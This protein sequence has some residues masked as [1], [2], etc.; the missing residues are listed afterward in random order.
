[1]APSPRTLVNKRPPATSLGTAIAWIVTL[2]LIVGMLGNFGLFVISLSVHFGAWF[3]D[4]AS[5]SLRPVAMVAGVGVALVV[6][7]GSLIAGAA[8]LG[9]GSGLAADR[10]RKRT[11]ILSDDIS[12]MSQRKGAKT[13]RTMLLTIKQESSRA[14]AAAVVTGGVLT[15]I[16]RQIPDP[17]ALWLA[18]SAMA[19][20]AVWTGRLCSAFP[21]WLGAGATFIAILV[22]QTVG[23]IALYTPGQQ[24]A[25]LPPESLA[26][27][28]I[29]ATSAACAAIGGALAYAVSR[30]SKRATPLFR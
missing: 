1:V 18:L 4:H 12:S 5:D 10:L 22:A 28:A 2:I 11:Q 23:A 3:A 17:P 24:P 25:V 30:V 8:A 13:Q 9:F 20:L 21:F 6:G 15:F 16:D 26:V 7:L 19:I 29:L 27:V 14:F